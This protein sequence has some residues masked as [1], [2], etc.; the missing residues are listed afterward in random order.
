[1][2]KFSIIIPA[3]NVA[4][5]LR[6]CLDSVLAQDFENWECVVVDDESTDE[7]PRILDEYA[8][9]DKRIHVVHQK[10]KG[11]GGARNSGIAAARGE[12]IFF[13]DGDDKMASGSLG[14]LNRIIE[15]HPYEKL[16]R[17][18]FEQYQDG[19]DW[20]ASCINVDT[21][22]KDISRQIQMSDFYTY[23]WQH[24]YRRDVIR[25]MLFKV[26]KRGCDRVFVDDVLLH[27][28][29]SFVETSVVFYGYRLRAGSAMNS[30]PSAQVLKDEMWHR[31][32]IVLMIA[33]SEKKV[34]YA[35]SGW[36]EGY[37]TNHVGALIM[38]KTSRER[39]ELWNVW[40]GCVD[41]M[42][43]AKGLS[44]RTRRIYSLCSHLRHQWF[45]WLLC[46]AWPWYNIH[47]FIP[48]AG[49]RILRLMK[50]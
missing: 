13:L 5:Y 38:R 24:L 42:R 39:E 37:F 9:K 21:V 44:A 6:E 20:N 1:M 4:P 22:R 17:F 30:V 8:A 35:G 33:A 28:V 11:E 23:V 40:I 18:G 16:I 25:R 49:R 48:R 36:L 50:G 41:E 34:D 47:G 26:Y 43:L 19:T 12:W 45:W 32:D 3:Y 27:R 14:C 31:R 15:Q 46:C 2:P 7:G 29:D 10:N